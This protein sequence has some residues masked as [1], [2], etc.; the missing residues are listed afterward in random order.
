M[1]LD[2][3]IVRYIR[4]VDGEGEPYE[5]WVKGYESWDYACII[6]Q[7]CDSCVSTFYNDNLVF[8]KEEVIDICESVVDKLNSIK[9]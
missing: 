1:A 8:D 9:D 3:F 4:V 5:K 7:E 2:K 6:H